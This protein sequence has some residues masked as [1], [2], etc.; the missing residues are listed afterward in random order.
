MTGAG[1]YNS[2]VSLAAQEDKIKVIYITSTKNLER[3]LH[4]YGLLCTLYNVILRTARNFLETRE[5]IKNSTH[6]FCHT[7][8]KWPILEIFLRKF[9]RLVLGLVGLID[10]KDIE[11]AQLI[12]S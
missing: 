11:V 5:N 6:P 9:Y 12:W 8:S 4:P 3:K 7:N 10:A 1:N 2:S